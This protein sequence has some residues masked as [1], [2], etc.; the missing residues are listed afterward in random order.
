MP[1]CL[2]PPTADTIDVLQCHP[3]DTALAISAGYDGEIG[4]WDLRSGTLL[5][6]FSRRELHPGGACFVRWEQ[7]RFPQSCATLI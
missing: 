5:R 1:A 2:S 6:K 7:G 4:V 3:S